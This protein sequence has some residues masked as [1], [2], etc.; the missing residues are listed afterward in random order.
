VRMSRVLTDAT[1]EEVE[2]VRKLEKD[3][4]AFMA[5][6]FAAKPALRLALAEASPSAARELLRRGCS[7][8]TALRILL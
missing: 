3:A 7:V 2:H 8:K 6:G 1:P 5:L 4:R